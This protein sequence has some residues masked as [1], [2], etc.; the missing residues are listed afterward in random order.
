M[1][2]LHWFF[3]VKNLASYALP[4]KATLLFHHKNITVNVTPKSTPKSFSPKQEQVCNTFRSAGKNEPR[5]VGTFINAVTAQNFIFD[6]DWNIPLPPR[7]FCPTS[8]P[9][10]PPFSLWADHRDQ[11]HCLFAP[12]AA[13]LLPFPGFII[14]FCPRFSPAAVDTMFFSH[15]VTMNYAVLSCDIFSRWGGAT[16]FSKN[17]GRRGDSTGERGVQIV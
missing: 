1:P 5:L 16:P 13:F 15:R 12:F 17:V 9:L 8:V 10:F 2:L 4:C 14:P 11:I 7:V 3:R 6:S